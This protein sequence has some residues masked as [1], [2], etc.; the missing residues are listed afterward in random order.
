MGSELVSVSPEP[1]PI[2]FIRSKWVCL[3]SDLA[4]AF[5]VET[6]RLNEIV[7]RK[8]AR[9]G[10][11]YTF[12]SDSE[13]WT[14]LRSQFATTSERAHGGRR[15]APWLFTEHGVVMVATLLD[16]DAA[17]N[18]SK[19]IVEVFVEANKPDVS[20]AIIANQ[21]PTAKAMKDRVQSLLNQV[22]DT[23]ID[24]ERNQTVRQEAQTLIAGFLASA[25][26]NLRKAGLENLELEAKVTKLLAEAEH[27]RE[28]TA[29]TRAETKEIEI[30]VFREQVNLL[31]ELLAMFE[32]GSPKA[33]PRMIRALQ[34][35]E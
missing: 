15:T 9:F 20:A 10:E 3:D 26:E 2:Y 17:V 33:I 1:L 25:R 27:E 24:V 32:G 31:Q 23:M 6:K 35:P 21:N 14:N 12:Q 19:L 7:K 34:L 13:E 11:Q 29:K 4:K 16:T 18:A 30:R 28:R 5:G 8:S 22:L